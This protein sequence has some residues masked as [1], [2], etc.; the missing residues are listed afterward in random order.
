MRRSPRFLVRYALGF[1]LALTAVSNCFNVLSSS[2]N[3]NSQPRAGVS[4]KALRPD[5]F[6]NVTLFTDGN[7]PRS[8]I[9]MNEVDGNALPALAVRASAFSPFAPN[10]TATKSHTPSGSVHPGDTLTYTVLITNS[11]TTDATGVN[12]SDTIDPNTTL[13]G[14][15]VIAS[16]IAVDDSYNTI[17]NV[18]ISVPVAQGVIANDLNPNGAGTLTVTK[19]NSTTV[20]GGG[21]ATDSTANGIVTM[22][23][24]GSFTYTPN[25][26]FRG[27]TD[28]FTY[29]LDN[30][31]GKI[32]TA[33]V[34][35]AV[36]GLV[37]FIDTA[38][39]PGGDGRLSSPFNCLVGAG[40]FDPA[41]SDIANDNI[42]VYSGSYT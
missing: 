37:W 25:V 4:T 32:D 28:S 5:Q 41:A 15:S 9:K 23:S 14:G 17:G 26:A 7:S 11:G 10:I 1:L 12:L 24:D 20:P 18:N 27:S 13:V 22:S 40:C 2:S 36:N 21:S 8:P 38:A 34:S 31:T 19:V 29:T 35:I 30:G 42:F 16:P 6:P 39:A 3:L 33:T